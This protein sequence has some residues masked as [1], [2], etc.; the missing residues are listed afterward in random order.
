[1]PLEIT[2]FQLLLLIFIPAFLLILYKC[3]LRTK[4]RPLA[5]F[6]LYLIY[7]SAQI[8]LRAEY[9]PFTAFP[10]GT[11][12]EE[13]PAKY[14][15][16]R[17]LEESGNSMNLPLSRVLPIFHGERAVRVIRKAALDPYAAQQTGS[18]Y[19]NAWMEKTGRAAS[20]LSEIHFEQWKWDFLRSKDDPE[21]GYKIKSL[22]YKPATGEAHA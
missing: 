21:R 10:Q 3:P 14:V 5:L 19:L 15:K 2:A 1:M 18:A 13:R 20:H 12:P 9:F 4:R 6:I 7:V 8:Y 17:V 22:T 11:F 16:V